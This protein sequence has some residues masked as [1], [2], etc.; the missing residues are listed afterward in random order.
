MLIEQYPVGWAVDAGKPESIMVYLIDVP[1]VAMQGTTMREALDKL[2]AFAP[3]V[4]ATYR[5]EGT[6]PPPSGEPA[7]EIGAVKVLRSQPMPAFMQLEQAAELDIGADLNLT[8][9]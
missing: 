6:L 5:E 7:L 1:G 8:A 4:L 9:A 3:N 2:A